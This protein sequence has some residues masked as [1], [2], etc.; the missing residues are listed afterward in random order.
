VRRLWFGDWQ[1]DDPEQTDTVVIRPDDGEDAPDPVDPRRNVRRGAI[2]AA[3][4]IFVAAVFA[5]SSGGNDDPATSEQSDVQVPQP[6]LQVPPNQ[7]P[8]TPPPQGFGGADLT[9]SAAT[10]A[11]Q[12]ALA[13]YPGDIERVTRDSTG[14][15]YVVHVIRPD[16]DE[17]HVLVDGDFQVQ[18]SDANSG[19]STLGPGPSQ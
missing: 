3:I 8:Q 18:G 7:V 12:A 19:P 15:G 4:A 16:G 5:L 13:Q 9:G 10:K 14:G 6:Q 11:A 2:A 1:R 17:V